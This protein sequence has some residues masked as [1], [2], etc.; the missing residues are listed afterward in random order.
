[1][2]QETLEKAA[3]LKRDID[4]LDLTLAAMEKCE[5]GLWDLNMKSDCYKYNANINTPLREMIRDT[6]S[7]HRSNLAEQLEKI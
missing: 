6:F 7:K 2:T 1:M 4:Y 3:R 5:K